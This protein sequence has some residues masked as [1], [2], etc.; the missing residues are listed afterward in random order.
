MTGRN[1]VEVVAPGETTAP[2]TET[3]H[4]IAIREAVVGGLVVLT[5]TIIGKLYIFTLSQYLGVGYFKRYLSS[6]K[7]QLLNF[8]LTYHTYLYVVYKVIKAPF[9]KH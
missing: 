3:A 8:P 1:V 7:A 9:F 5:V 2:T 6:Y 4:M